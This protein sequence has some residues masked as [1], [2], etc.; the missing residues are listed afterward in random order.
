MRVICNSHATAKATREHGV[1]KKILHAIPLGL[2]DALHATQNTEQLQT[3]EENL[4][5]SFKNDFVLLTVGRLIKRK[6]VVWF[7]QNVLPKLAE[8]QPNVRYLV[9]GGGQEQEAI[10]QVIQKTS[11]QKFVRLLGRIDDD[12]LV[13]LYNASHVF[14]QPNIFV[15]GDMEGFGRVLLEA[16]LHKLSVVASG[17]EGILDAV[18]HDK[19]G[20]LVLNRKVQMIF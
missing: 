1:S 11:M 12:Q 5:I 19:N 13:A 16:S 20:V 2:D 7:I 18:K 17:M 4:R 3:L 9:V 8:T 6:G 15:E 14:V 10:E